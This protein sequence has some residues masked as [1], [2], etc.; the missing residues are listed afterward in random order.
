MSE[1]TRV[2]LGFNDDVT[3][4]HGP[5]SVE[6]VE[7][8]LGVHVVFYLRN[9]GRTAVIWCENSVSFMLYLEFHF[10]W[11]FI[12]LE[13]SPYLNFRS[14]RVQLIKYVQLI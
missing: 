8:V 14:L 4:L 7:Q 12:L 13:V 10:T 1:D 3:G 6:I 9:T 11:S 5:V 2:L